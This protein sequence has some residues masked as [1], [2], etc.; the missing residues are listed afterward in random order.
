MRDARQSEGICVAILGLIALSLLS[1]ATTGPGGKRSF[2]MIGTA[3][4][5]ALGRQMA[6][7]V[8]S[9]Q[10]VLSDP[11]LTAY[12]SQVGGKI[13]AVSD[14]SDLPFHFKVLKS[15][16]V[17]AFA[18]PGGYVYVY[19]GLMEKLDNEAELAGVLSHEIS[20]V[21]ARHAVKRIQ[22]VYGYQVIASLALGGRAASVTGTILNAGV[23]LVVLGYGRANEFEADYDG[24][25]YMEKAGYNPDGMLQLLGEIESLSKHQP[26][27]LEKLIS[28]HPPTQERIGRIKAEIAAFPPEAQTL[29]LYADPYLQ[30]KTRLK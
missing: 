30:M 8:E 11:V 17:N 14:R 20:H 5:V 13:V 16:E 22:Q 10:R 29:P 15:D 6:W 2:I 18:L 9:Q 3:D 24:T 23:S 21:V 4:E 25:Y 19:S 26:G 7:Q 12:V 27:A 1:C 28:T